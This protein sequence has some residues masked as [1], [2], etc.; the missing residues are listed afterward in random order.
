LAMFSG[1]CRAKNA[2][3]GWPPPPPGWS[4]SPGWQP[5]P[6]WPPPPAGWQW[7]RPTRRTRRQR[8]GLGLLIGVPAAI[9]VLL[10]A[11]DV[12]GQVSGCGSIDPTDPLNY[13]SFTIVNDTS[14]IV[15]V[16]DCS[17]AYCDTADLPRRPNAGGRF[18]DH[19]ACGASG[20]DMTSWRIRSTDGTLLGYIALH[21]PRK[22]NG[23]IFDVSRSSRDRRTPTPP[24]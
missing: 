22:H 15:V 23:L 8:L 10:L 2:A 24:S 7:W 4:P 14:S 17:G 16:D 9:V 13:S 6:S 19:A 5:D 1:G 21:S 20:R 3:P 12:A 18:A 11:A